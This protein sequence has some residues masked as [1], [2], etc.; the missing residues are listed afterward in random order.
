MG[1]G[2]ANERVAAETYDLAV[3]CGV[4]WTENKQDLSGVQFISTATVLS[5]NIYF[6]LIYIYI[7]I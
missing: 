1:C 3:I 2:I 6:Y 7:Y 5:V 4:N